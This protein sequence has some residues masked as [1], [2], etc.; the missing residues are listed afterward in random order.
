MGTDNAIVRRSI[1]VVVPCYD[2]ED[3]VE[4]LARR[5]GAMFDS[6]PSYDWRAI[7]VENGSHDST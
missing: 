4:E 3:C 2:E 6:E 1:D 7:L 5:L